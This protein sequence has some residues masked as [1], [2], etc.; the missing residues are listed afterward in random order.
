MDNKLTLAVKELAYR[1]GA[2]LC[3]VANI[4]R[5][6]NAP[7]RM[8]PQGILPSA[9]SVIVCAV[10]HPDAA[11][12][13]G[14]EKHPQDIGPYSIQYIMNDKLDL[15][16]F[17]IA[18]LLDDLGYKTVPIASSNIWRYR[19][20]KEMEATF[21][22]DISHIYGA[23]CAGLGEL[24]WNGLCITPEYGARNRFVS[25]IT[26]AELTRQLDDFLAQWARDKQRLGIDSFADGTV[27]DA[28]QV[29]AYVGES[30]KATI[31]YPE[32]LGIVAKR[33]D[34]EN[35]VEKTYSEPTRVAF[36]GDSITEGHSSNSPLLYSYPAHYLALEL[37][38]G[39]DVIVSNLGVSA[40]GMLPST[41]YSKL[42]VRQKRDLCK[43]KE[44]DLP[45]NLLVYGPVILPSSYCALQKTEQFFRS[46]HH[47]FSLLSKNWEAYSEIAKRLGETMIITNEEMYGAVSALSAKEFGIKNPKLLAANSKIELA[48]RMKTEFYASP[49]QIRS[50][51]NLDQSVIDELFGKFG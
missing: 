36:I 7:I 18:R 46:P 44:I 45:G 31:T 35:G 39:N 43:S 42:T 1:L 22:P 41:R 51:L 25:I 4:E 29:K 14:G 33:F 15:L 30:K 3:G 34:V 2:D 38:A 27:F 21:A 19:G 17:R 50:I 11:I 40:S 10:H 9:K 23:V 24:G 8:S 49:K 32:N 12:E 20:Y 28:T 13:L 37:A 16:S 48:R 26:E 5:Y 6:E 47:Y